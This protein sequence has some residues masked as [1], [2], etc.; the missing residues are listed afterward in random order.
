MLT[1][2]LWQSSWVNS[3]LPPMWDPEMN[4]RCSDLVANVCTY[5]TVWQASW[6]G[7]LWMLGIKL[8]SSSIP[9]QRFYWLGSPLA[10][11][12]FSMYLLKLA[13][14]S[15]IE[16]ANADSII[17]IGLCLGE[18]IYQEVAPWTYILMYSPRKVSQRNL[19]SH[20]QCL[21]KEQI[22]GDKVGKPK[23]S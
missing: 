19:Y 14:T 5:F 1:D 11:S 20:L 8:Q 16:G 22:D 9:S 7:C 2:N 23:P 17:S 18:V 12:I 15:T 10:F 21:G 3:L 4:I 13:W 6:P